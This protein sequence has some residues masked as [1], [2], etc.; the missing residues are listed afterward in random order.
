MARM[1]GDEDKD[2]GGENS[3]TGL[4]CAVEQAEKRI[5]ITDRARSP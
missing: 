1:S 5:A 4:F 3:V 2:G